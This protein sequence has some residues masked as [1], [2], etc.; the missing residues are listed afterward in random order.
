M[1]SFTSR[2][3]RCSIAEFI[4]KRILRML[5]YSNRERQH[6]VF[7]EIRRTGVKNWC[8]ISGIQGWGDQIL[9][10]S[11][12]LLIHLV[13]GIKNFYREEAEEMTKKDPD[14][15]IRYSPTFSSNCREVCKITSRPMNMAIK[16]S[17][18]EKRHV[19]FK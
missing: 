12:E 17:R 6:V 14:Y 16:E 7:I 9:E 19:F 5:R 3:T 13:Q 4:K 11:D 8:S 1:S 10:P 2:Q 15:A 18:K